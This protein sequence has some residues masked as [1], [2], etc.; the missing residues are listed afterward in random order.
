MGV[1]VNVLL[2]LKSRT[3]WDAP[4]LGAALNWYTGFAPTSVA[5]AVQVTRSPTSWGAGSLGTREMALGKVLSSNGSRSSLQA[6]GLLRGVTGRA[7]PAR[8]RAEPISRE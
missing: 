4:L 6:V 2:G 8:V 3:T 7:R 5:V 1:H